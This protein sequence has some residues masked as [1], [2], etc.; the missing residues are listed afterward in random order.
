M[1]PRPKADDP[2]YTDINY[3]YAGVAGNIHEVVN[4]AGRE[5]AKVGFPDKKI[6]YYFLDDLDRDETAAKGTFHDQA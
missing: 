6:V 4:I 2:N 3:K 1:V 5:L